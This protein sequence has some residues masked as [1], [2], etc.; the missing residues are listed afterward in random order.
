M[1]AI[2]PSKLIE[3]SFMGTVGSKKRACASSKADLAANVHFRQDVEIATHA[4]L[5]MWIP[6]LA[7]WHYKE[8]IPSGLLSQVEG[9]GCMFIRDNI[10]E[11][12][13]NYWAMFAWCNKCKRLEAVHMLASTFMKIGMTRDLDKVRDLLADSDD[14]VSHLCDTSVCSNPTPS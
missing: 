6:D 5:T 9:L 3:K 13:R 7:P 14:H 12:K 1:D 11:G 2:W 4:T 8:A 10:D